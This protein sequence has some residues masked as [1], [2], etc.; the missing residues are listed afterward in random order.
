LIIYTKWK[1]QFR[2]TDQPEKNKITFITN[3]IV[4]IIQLITIVIVTYIYSIRH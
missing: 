3:A 4:I 2:K 1:K